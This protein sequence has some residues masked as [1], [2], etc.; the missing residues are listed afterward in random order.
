MV[1][2][3]IGLNGS[4]KTRR[5]V[6]MAR[7]VIAAENGDVI[8]V[9]NEDKLTYD[10]P[11]RARLVDASAFDIGS[12]EFIKGFICGIRSSNYD[13]T[14]I[15]IDN[16]HKLV[17][18]KSGDAFA[19]FVLWLNAFSEKEKIDFVLSSKGDPEVINASIKQFLI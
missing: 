14:H 6:D 19:A 3:I 2:L 8:V 17:N 15:Y 11:Y 13:I 12:Y 7:E 16:F 1:Q 9:E 5:L 18:D 4:G 10:I